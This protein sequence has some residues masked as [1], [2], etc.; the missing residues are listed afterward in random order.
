MYT[1][2]CVIIPLIKFGFHRQKLW[3]KIHLL[4]TCRNYSPINT[5]IIFKKNYYKVVGHN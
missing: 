2:T 5:K 4:P 3:Q 1:R